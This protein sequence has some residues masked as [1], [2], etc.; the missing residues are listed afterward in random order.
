MVVTSPLLYHATPPVM[1]HVV[2]F[3]S[4][5]HRFSSRYVR[6]WLS[7]RVMLIHR[8]RRQHQSGSTK[9]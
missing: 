5:T 6:A 4:V 2:G 1:Y 7:P 8:V 9:Q 3:D